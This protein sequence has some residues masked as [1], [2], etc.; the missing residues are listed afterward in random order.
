MTVAPTVEGETS[1]VPDENMSGENM[2]ESTVST[3]SVNG[4]N[5]VYSTHVQNIGWQASVSN[6]N[7]S[8]TTGLGYRL[9]GIKIAVNGSDMGVT[10]RTHVQ[11]YGWQS[12]VNN[13]E[14]SG[15]VGQAKRLEAHP[16]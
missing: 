3:E 9:E 4:A 2:A 8:G 1:Q 10:Y 14:V 6:G 12:Y 16:D 7:V 13:N 11:D 5:I 15:T